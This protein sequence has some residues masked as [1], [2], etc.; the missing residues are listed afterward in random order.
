MID[1]DAHEYKME[2]D[3]HYRM[4]WRLYKQTPI[5]YNRRNMEA[6]ELEERIK[7]LEARLEQADRTLAAA[8][9]LGNLVQVDWITS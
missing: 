7:M 2:T 6:F 1:W 5:D 8:G 4:Q 9:L 3:E